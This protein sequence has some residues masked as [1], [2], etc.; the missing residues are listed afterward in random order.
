M[1][2]CTKRGG[3]D[4][5]NDTTTMT[6]SR[7]ITVVDTWILTI[8]IQLK[9]V[10]CVRPVFYIAPVCYVQFAIGAGPEAA[11]TTC[12][13][14]LCVHAM[15][16]MPTRPSWFYKSDAAMARGRCES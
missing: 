2:V 4:P 14:I 10:P 16:S 7:P 11:I 6:T 13:P 15:F 9:L 1:Y 12:T 3:K 5:G 8:T